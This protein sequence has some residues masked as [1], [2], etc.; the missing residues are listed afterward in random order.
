MNIAN[1]TDEVPVLAEMKEERDKKALLLVQGP[2]FRIRLGNRQGWP[3]MIPFPYPHFIP[4]P[5]PYI[6][7]VLV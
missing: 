5:L 1:K 3:E 7:K 4:L 6:W 2:F